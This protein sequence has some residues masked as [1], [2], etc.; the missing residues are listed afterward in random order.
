M[1][2]EDNLVVVAVGGRIIH[3]NLHVQGKRN[4]MKGGGLQSNSHSDVS[5][6]L[7]K[8]LPLYPVG[9]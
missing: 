6:C 1:S 9:V 2:P 8:L 7:I 5:L 4:G 3:H